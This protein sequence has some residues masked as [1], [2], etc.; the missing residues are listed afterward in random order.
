MAAGLTLAKTDFEPF[1]EAINTVIADSLNHLP[2]EPVAMSDGGLAPSDLTVSFAEQLEAA[3]PWG[4]HFA[5]PIFDNTFV[6]RRHRIVG[7]KHLKLVLSMVDDSQHIIDA[8]A[9]NVDVTAW[10]DPKA[11]TI[12]AAYRL[13]VNRFRNRETVQLIIQHI[14]KVS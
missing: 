6:V 14:E 12:T 8:I 11:T 9:F 10:P 2:P 13:D 5:E 7:E 1:C 3:G 4:Q